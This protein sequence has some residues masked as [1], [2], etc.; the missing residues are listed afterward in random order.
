MSTSVTVK[1]LGVNLAH[2]VCEWHL[3]WLRLNRSDVVNSSAT[4]SHTKKCFTVVFHRGLVCLSASGLRFLLLLLAL[5]QERRRLELLFLLGWG[6]G[7]WA[8]WGATL[9]FG[10]RSSRCGGGV[11]GWESLHPFLQFLCRLLL[12]LA[13]V[14]YGWRLGLCLF[15][16]KYSENKTKHRIFSNPTESPE[17]GGAAKL[18]ARHVTA[19][20]H[21]CF[22]RSGLSYCFSVLTSETRPKHQKCA[23][24]ISEK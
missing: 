12:L 1:Y 21:A 5:F 24:R 15:C 14:L 6:L 8:L 22:M 9:W 16:S 10:G 7:G 2:H 13:S 4:P 18:H 19:N 11:V 20:E 3:N 23:L 17:R